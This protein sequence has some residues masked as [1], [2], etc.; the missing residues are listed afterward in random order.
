MS[1]ILPALL[2]P[3][4]PLYLDSTML[5]SFRNCP[6][7][8]YNEHVL[9]LRGGGISIDLHCGGCFAQ[10]L[11]TT[12]NCYFFLGM[13]FTDALLRGEADF[14][15][16]WG[17]VKPRTREGKDG[18][19]YVSA[20]TRE[21]TWEA[22]EAYFAKYPIDT[23]PVQPFLAPGRATVEFTFALPLTRET[24]G[25]DFPLHPSGEPFVYTGRYDMLGTYG[26]YKHPIIKDEKSAGK[27]DMH[28]AEKWDLRNQFIGYVWATR[29]LGIPVIGI[30]VRGVVILKEELHFP[31]AIKAGTFTDVLLDRWKMQLSRDIFRI[32][33]C[34]NTGYFDYDFGDTCTDFGLCAFFH[35]CRSDDP[36]IWLKDFPVRRWN[37]LEKIPVAE[38]VK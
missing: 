38:E 31:E 36:D 15:I 37:P 23:D 13:S 10:A 3:E 26:P 22:V 28:W 35:A 30:C 5:I 20:K 9:G 17:D 1:I 33:D 16:K 4:L 21:R 14:L 34:W 11:E 18:P 32:V 27:T 25:Y 29:L 6:R 24:T 2:K 7:K 12:Y 19:I 8:F